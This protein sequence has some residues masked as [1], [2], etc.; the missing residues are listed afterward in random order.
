M[1]VVLH[2]DYVVYQ[3]NYYTGTKLCFSQCYI[4]ISDS[5]A[6]AKQGEGTFEWAVD[7]LIHIDCLLF[8]KSGMVVMKLCAVSSNAGPSIHISCT[9]DIEELKIVFVDDN[10][11]L[12]QE[13]ITSLNGKYLA[14]WNTVSDFQESFEK[15]DYPKGDLNSVCIT[16]SDFDLLKPDTFIND[17]IIDFYIQYLKSK[18]QKEESHRYHFFNSF[19]FR[20]LVDMDRNPSSASDGK[21]AF[22]RVRRWTRKVNLFEKDYIFIPVNFKLHWSLIVICHPGEVVKFNDKEPDKALK[23]PCVLHMDSMRGYHSDLK[24]IFQS[25]LWEEWKERQKDTCGEDLSSRFLNMHFLSVPSPQQDNMFDCGLF[26]LHC[27]ELFLDEAPF[28]FNPFKLTKF[29]NFLNLDWFHPVEVSLKRPFIQRLIFELAENENHSLH[30]GFP[31]D[32]N[33][34]HRYSENNKNRTNS[35]RP[36]V[37]G[38]SSLSHSVQGKQFTLL[39][40]PSPLDPQSF[41]PSDMVLKEH[42][43]PGTM[44]GTSLGHCQSLDQQSSDHYLNGSIFSTKD[45]TDLNE[46]LMHIMANPNFQQVSP[47]SFSLTYLTGGCE[48]EISHGPRIGIQ[49]EHDKIESFI[50]TPSCASGDSDIEIIENF[51]TR[52]ETRSSYEDE[53][54]ENNNTAIENYFEQ[55][56]DIPGSL[57]ENSQWPNTICVGHNNGDQHLSY[58]Q[59]EHSKTKPSQATSTCAYASDDIAMIGNFPIINETRS[60]Y[61]DEQ[62]EK[63]NTAIEDY[64]EHFP[65]IP[66]SHMEFSQWPNTST[67]ASANPD[68]IAITESF[69]IRNETGLSYDDQRAEYNN[70]AMEN[71]FEHL[72]E[73]PDSLVEFSQRSNPMCV[74]DNNGDQGL[75]CQET[76]AMQMDQVSN[77][78]D[79]KFTCDDDDL[80]IIDSMEPD[81]W[82]NQ[83]IKKRRMLR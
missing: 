33:E 63:N 66:D 3:D 59:S 44:A 60:P 8:P 6:C 1:E 69:P 53:R 76:P 43:K 36:E 56:S 70:A 32:Y 39:S 64:F 22:Q 15:V 80:V 7:D 82:K 72:P 11:S 49:S 38:D 35:L 2:P 4:Q 29:S 37:N 74:S 58:I 23:V 83:P 41:N 24:N 10:W 81:H 26:L 31:S 57:M 28:N 55:V 42:F 5:T 79:D 50:A 12:R 48:T 78:L 54:G 52:N 40:A 71:F 9:S 75:Y 67:Y 16:K 47:Q 51:P 19:F 25:Y 61:E 30:E 46:E 13:Q 14:I 45:G 27:I 77:A 17:T 20:K 21:A 18:I 68:N 34:D 65:E 73:I 62:G